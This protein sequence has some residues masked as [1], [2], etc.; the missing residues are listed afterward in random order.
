MLGATGTKAAK[1]AQSA[2]KYQATPKD[3]KQCDGC[4]LFAA[5]NARRRHRAKRMVRALGQE[6][7]LTIPPLVRAG[8]DRLR[9]FAWRVPLYNSNE[10]LRL[11]LRRFASDKAQI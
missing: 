11:F 6:G 8:R 4:N 1:L 3:G 10:R 7:G 9:R 5:P 2:A